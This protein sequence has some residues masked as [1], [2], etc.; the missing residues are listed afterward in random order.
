M[1]R[2]RLVANPDLFYYEKNS[3]AVKERG[4]EIETL[5]CTIAR[6]LVAIPF[7]LLGTVPDVSAIFDLP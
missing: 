7:N 2:R 6:V 5:F 4:K 1:K 3:V